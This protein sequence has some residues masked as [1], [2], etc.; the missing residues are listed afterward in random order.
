MTE[1]KVI[2]REPKD[3]E[4]RASK[5]LNAE[6]AIGELSPGMELFVLTYGQFSLIDT[7][8][9]LLEKTGPADMVLSIWTAGNTDTL[10]LLRL[11]KAGSLRSARLILDRSFITRQPLRCRLVLDS[12]GLE[13]VRTWRGHGKFLVLRNEKWFLSIRTSMNLNTNPRLETLEISDD[14]ALGDFLWTIADDLFR[15]QEVGI[16]HGELPELETVRFMDAV[17]VEAGT[18]R[19][20]GKVVPG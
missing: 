13:A 6:K 8:G 10:E 15:E 14:P 11:N 19:G 5:F 7:I 3:R 1:A 4:V 2:R 17:T 9:A 16:L 12:F 20:L 18:V